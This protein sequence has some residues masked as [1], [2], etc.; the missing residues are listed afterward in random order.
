M[1]DRTTTVE[2]STPAEHHNRLLSAMERSSSTA[3]EYARAL[4]ALG[5]RL[6]AAE[7][8]Y[9]LFEAYRRRDNAQIELVT[10]MLAAANLPPETLHAFLLSS[11]KN[12]NSSSRGCAR[13]V[14]PSTPHAMRSKTIVLGQC[15]R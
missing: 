12:S 9:A 15:T 1:T 2:P 6:T 3:R 14:S 4:I 11:I 13:G 7:L 8:D 5:A 10:E